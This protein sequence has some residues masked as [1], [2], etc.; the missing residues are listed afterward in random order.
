MGPGWKLYDLLAGAGS[1]GDSRWLGRAAVLAAQPGLRAR[2]LHGGIQYWDAQ[3]DD[4]RLA[5][6]LMR[7]G[8]PGASCLN[9]VALTGLLKPS[10]GGHVSGARLRD[11]ENGEEFEVR[12]KAVINATGVHADAVRRLDETTAP[13][14]LTHSQ[15]VHLVVDGGFF[16]APQPCWCRRPPTAAC[17]SRSHGR[18]RC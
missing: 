13:P 3:F 5:I 8:R 12:A 7:G 1:L 11:V 9:H 17:C 14:L 2:G 18:A 4:A 10:P 6:A 15:G 16:P